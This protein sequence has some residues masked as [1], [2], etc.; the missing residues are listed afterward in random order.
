[1]T[2]GVA[3]S[4][5]GGR[6]TPLYGIASATQT[7]AANGSSY[8]DVNV[9]AAVS[10]D[11]GRSKPLYGIAS[12]T[13]TFAANASSYINKSHRHPEPVEVRPLRTVGKLQLLYTL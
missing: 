5:D 12:A 3:V 6:S 10:R 1:M 2:V 4:Y 13:Q 7:F 8:S 9:G 11:G